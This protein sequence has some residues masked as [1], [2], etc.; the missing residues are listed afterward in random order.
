MTAGALCHYSGRMT[1][2]IALSVA[3]L[4]LRSL[5]QIHGV[6]PHRLLSRGASPGS[7]RS[8]P[9]SLV[10]ASRQS[11]CG[12]SLTLVCKQCPGKSPPSPCDPS[13]GLPW[14]RGLS[15]SL[16]CCLFPSGL[17]LTRPR[18]LGEV[19]GGSPHFTGLGTALPLKAR[20]PGPH[21]QRRTAPCQPGPPA[22]Y[23]RDVELVRKRREAMF[24][25]CFFF[26]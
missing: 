4:G 18:L 1:P 5:L 10:P 22:K 6:C 12:F 8:R 17:T 9:P 20:M 23:F 3:W 2:T 26:I 15:V 16:P 13:G 21:Q 25:R 11:V 24:Q 14:S 7:Q 19:T